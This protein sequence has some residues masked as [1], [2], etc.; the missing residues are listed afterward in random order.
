MVTRDILYLTIGTLLDIVVKKNFSLL[1]VGWY[2]FRVMSGNRYLPRD[3]NGNTLCITSSGNV[4]VASWVI[5]LVTIP[6][7]DFVMIH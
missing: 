3:S 1:L 2:V 4:F 7:L 6:L 5:P